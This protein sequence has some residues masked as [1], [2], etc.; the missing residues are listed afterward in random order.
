MHNF[1]I[2]K[3][4]KKKVQYFLFLICSYFLSPIAVA[5]TSDVVT[6]KAQDNIAFK[7]LEE[8]SPEQ[9]ECEL[10][11][12]KIQGKKVQKKQEQL[13]SQLSPMVR[14][15]LI[16]SLY[17]FEQQEIELYGN[18][19]Y[20]RLFS[21]IKKVLDPSNVK[22]NAILNEENNGRSEQYKISSEKLENLAS[23]LHQQYKIWSIINK[24]CHEKNLEHKKS[25]EECSNS[26]K[27]IALNSVP[28]SRAGPANQELKQPNNSHLNQP[29]S[30]NIQDL[31]CSNTIK[32]YPDL[33]NGGKHISQI[34]DEREKLIKCLNWCLNDE[35]LKIKY[36]KLCDP[37]NEQEVRA[38]GLLI[39]QL[40]PGHYYNYR[41]HLCE[42]IWAPVGQDPSKRLM[43]STQICEKIK[44]TGLEIFD[45]ELVYE[46]G[47][48]ATEISQKY[49][50]H[51]PLEDDLVERE[52]YA[53]SYSYYPAIVR[54]VALTRMLK[55]NCY[56]DK[57]TPK[58][59]L[60]CV[61]RFGNLS[62]KNFCQNFPEPNNDQ[63]KESSQQ[64]TDL[65]KTRREMQQKFDDSKFDA[66]KLALIN[67]ATIPNS[68]SK[69]YTE[70]QD[71]ESN[72]QY[73][74]EMMFRLATQHPILISDFNKEIKKGS[75]QEQDLDL[76]DNGILQK[77][78]TSTYK[79]IKKI[80]KEGNKKT[81][82]NLIDSIENVCEMSETELIHRSEFTGPTLELFPQFHDAHFCYQN[83]FDEQ[84]LKDLARQAGPGLAL[85]CLPLGFGGPPGMY[86]SAACGSAYLGYAKMIY[87][88]TA[89]TLVHS[90]RC[91]QAT[92]NWE[93]CESRRLSDL[94]AQ[95]SVAKIDYYI[96]AA[97][98]PIEAI[99]AIAPD[100]IRAVNY[101][102]KINEE[103][104]LELAI[105]I[106]KIKKLK[107]IDHQRDRAKLL[108][109]D[110]RFRFL[111]NEDEL[112]YI[113]NRANYK[114]PNPIDWLAKPE[115]II[116]HQLKI[117]NDVAE[118]GIPLKRSNGEAI[119]VGE[120]KYHQLHD[121]SYHN[122][123]MLDVFLDSR[124]M[125]Q[126]SYDTAPFEVELSKIINNEDVLNKLFS[127]IPPNKM[128]EFKKQLDFFINEGYSLE[129]D[130]TCNFSG[131]GGYFS[132]VRKVIS[133][134]APPYHYTV[135]IHEFQ[136]LTLHRYI[137]S[138]VFTNL[139]KLLPASGKLDNVKEWQEVVRYLT[140][141]GFY[142]ERDILRL[143]I[144]T[145][146]HLPYTGLHE[147]LSTGKEIDYLLELTKNIT[148]VGENPGFLS[149][150]YTRFAKT[151]NDYV[152]NHA[153]KVLL[154]KSNLNAQEQELLELIN[155]KGRWTDDSE[156]RANLLTDQAFLGPTNLAEGLKLQL[157][158]LKKVFPVIAPPLIIDALASS[159]DIP[160]KSEY[161]NEET[162]DR[163]YQLDS[164]FIKISGEKIFV[165]SNDNLLPTRIQ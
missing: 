117:L 1:F 114:S 98:L 107:S 21:E 103:R 118:M 46:L 54:K 138:D 128:D 127:G 151:K 153:R 32:L 35:E 94:R 33:L 15:L 97:L 156:F 116:F 162:D 139:K 83:K 43:S 140:E 65:F 111:F 61:K 19:N 131:C 130:P 18:V 31:D 102:Q 106:E 76:I 161:I 26:F 53:N 6:T 132:N 158:K 34:I 86:L 3:N 30:E 150:N 129:I 73:I 51:S 108:L 155:K 22:L 69:L 77:L 62:S 95:Y 79:S 159:G 5:I 16:Q 57:K 110:P 119:F 125:A 72:L 14:E 126:F 144:A 90:Q 11:A 4:R 47:G 17:E 27:T 50:E 157:E 96:S 81:R 63:L 148:Q 149:L 85:L 99:G 70:Y 42:G 101:A 36:P 154:Q 160:I 28:Y 89:T 44:G 124:K 109:K 67:K 38:R 152:T 12:A 59:P 64:L 87:D 7:L 115:E 165:I 146:S 104:A 20:D 133:M 10:E 163:I 80:I 93:V 88:D 23:E 123:P 84:D 39:S 40:D 100:L 2:Q 9:K 37:Q 55:A 66:L 147:L 121:F 136:H 141:T 91:F 135:W 45:A 48:A 71:L 29:G 142:T 68:L 41:S 8:C 92:G 58:L 145:E 82:K 137:T 24:K 105:E 78:N 113:K 112:K 60:S 13:Y 74:D 134:P 164:G 25:T 143:K 122:S 49:L 120:L 56:F 75:F 52:F